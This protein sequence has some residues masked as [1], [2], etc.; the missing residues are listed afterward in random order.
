M[1]NIKFSVSLFVCCLVLVQLDQIVCGDSE[2][3]V[4][5]DIVCDQAFPKITKNAS[6]SIKANA[7]SHIISHVYEP[8][9]GLLLEYHSNYES[10]KYI[11]PQNS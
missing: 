5:N 9:D 3:C 2:K 8:L 10:S 7:S 4:Q 6:K 1:A 11:C